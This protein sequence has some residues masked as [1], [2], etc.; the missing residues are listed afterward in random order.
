MWTDRSV[1]SYELVLHTTQRP[2]ESAGA[3]EM[4]RGS[5]WKT[6]TPLLKR[7]GQPPSTLFQNR[8]TF[9]CGGRSRWVSQLVA[10]PRWKRAGCRPWLRRRYLPGATMPLTGSAGAASAAPARGKSRL[11]RRCRASHSAALLA[12]LRAIVCPGAAWPLGAARGRAAARRGRADTAGI[13]QAL[14]EAQRGGRPS[15][16]LHCTSCW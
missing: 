6:E 2:R 16:L 8:F 10:H 14:G 15:V 5:R 13:V 7:R 4:R 11:F 12:Q 1:S 3:A 9:H